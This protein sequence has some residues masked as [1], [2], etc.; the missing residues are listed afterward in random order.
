M[1]VNAHLARKGM[2]LR[3]GTIVDAMIIDA[4]SSTK[5]SDGKRDPEMHQTKKGN[6]W[7]F[8][9]KAHIGMDEHSGLVHHAHCT[10]AYV[11]DVT[12]VQHLLYGKEDEIYGDSGHIGTDKREQLQDVTASFFI[13]EKPSHIAKIESQKDRRYALRWEHFK[14]SVRAKIEHPFRVIK[15]QFGYTKVRYR[16]LV[17]NIAPVLML[18]ALSNLWMARKQLLPR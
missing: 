6:Q 8:G 12:Q 9:M 15:R 2:S 16:G 17:K 4:P 11:G 10:A 18:F 1:Q 13:A 3:A 5:S 14:A 7:F